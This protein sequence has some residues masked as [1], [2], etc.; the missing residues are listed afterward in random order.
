MRIPLKP[1]LLTLGSLLFATVGLASTSIWTINGPGVWTGITNWSAVVPTTTSNVTVTLSAAT[2][3][4]SSSVTISSLTLTGGTL[5]FSSAANITAGAYILQGGTANVSL[6]GN[7]ILTKNSTTTATLSR[8]NTYTGG[9]ILNAG[10]LKLGNA[11][12]LGTGMLTISN[13]T[14]PVPTLDVTSNLTVAN[15]ETWSSS[16]IFAGTNSLTLSGAVALTA[17]DT[18]TLSAGTLAATGVISGNFSLTQQGTG[19]GTLVLANANT[20]TGGTTLAVGTLALG[21]A[22]ALGT[23]NVTINGGTLDASAPVTANN[24]QI[25]GGNFSFAGSNP[26]TM[27]GNVTLSANR[28]LTL[29]AGALTEAGII[30]GNFSLGTQGNGTLVLS[31][32]NTYTGTTTVSQGNLNIQNATALGATGNGTTVLNGASLQIQGGITTAEPLTLNGTGS[33]SNGALENVSGT[34]TVSG[35]VT[36]SGATLF[37]ADTGSTLTV[38]GAI[39]TTTSNVTV[40]GGGNLTLSGIIGLSGDVGSLTKNGTGTLTLSAANLFS[41]GTTINS[42]TVVA[43]AA[44]GLGLTL[45]TITING[46]ELDTSGSLGGGQGY[47]ITGTGGNIV[48]TNNGSIGSLGATVNAIN[49][50]GNLSIPGAYSVNLNV[51]SGFVA[52]LG[53]VTMGSGST[54]TTVANGLQVVNGGTLQA[55]GNGTIANIVANSLAILTSSDSNGDPVYLDTTV[56]GPSV[57]GQ[58]LTFTGALDGTGD[59]YGNIRLNNTF[60]PGTNVAGNNTAGLVTI[61]GNVVLGTA[62]I[63]TMNIGGT[64]RGSGTSGYDAINVKSGGTLTRSGSLVVTLANGFVPSAGNVFQLFR[65]SDPAGG[66]G[67]IVG[68]FG[69]GNSQI[70]LPSLASFGLAWDSSSLISLGMLDVIS[71]IPE[72][73]VVAALCGATVLL[74]ATVKRRRLR[75]TAPSG[76]AQT[77]A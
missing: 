12:A 5:S 49:F 10:T 61:H 40:G 65:T 38:S 69:T 33:A 76:P 6:G 56:R 28:V 2:L 1:L 51:P 19:N 58:Q 60:T 48:I 77:S 34:N 52:T 31:G 30:G 4:N 9:T 55:L 62:D 72:P 44:N 43:A 35:T 46:G 26:L 36:L 18:V 39:K 37:A 14:T 17:N 13:T 32:A 54:I 20:Y 15:L 59:Y 7:A 67:S 70:S 11:T 57:A 74:Y 73:S 64:V 53:N 45:N 22:A 50:S 42:G 23:G 3:T 68:S 21:N 66:S 27:G 24:F 16:F 8:A 71:S 25:W 41:G 75:A 47:V 63:L 29:N